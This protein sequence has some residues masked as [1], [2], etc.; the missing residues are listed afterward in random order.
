MNDKYKRFLPQDTF[1]KETLKDIAAPSLNPNNIARGK[2]LYQGAV[3]GS[4]HFKDG[5]DFKYFNYAPET[6]I[7]QAMGKNFTRR[8]AEDIASYIR[9]IPGKPNPGRPWNPT[10]QPGPETDS[11]PKKQI[12]G[13]SRYYCGLTFRC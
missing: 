4:C 11:K 12:D 2:R 6:I 3:C 9:T 5:S 13:R 8:Q 1:V 7:F 10:F